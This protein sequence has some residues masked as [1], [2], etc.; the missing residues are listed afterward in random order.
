MKRARRSMK[1]RPALA[2]RRAPPGSGTWWVWRLKVAGW[3]VK[4]PPPAMVPFLSLP[5]TAL[6]A[7]ARDQV[8]KPVSLVGLGKRQ[9]SAALPVETRSVTRAHSEVKLTVLE[10]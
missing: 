10:S 7:S 5:K 4:S 9:E 3:T 6:S 1:R 2:M 8:R